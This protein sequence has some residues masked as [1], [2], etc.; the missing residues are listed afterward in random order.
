[1]MRGVGD[2]ICFNPVNLT[3]SLPSQNQRYT[4]LHKYTHKHT[5]IYL[6]VFV[7]CEVYLVSVRQAIFFFV[8]D[9]SFSF[10]SKRK[11]ERGK[12]WMEEK[13]EVRQ[14]RVYKVRAAAGQTSHDATHICQSPPTIHP[15]PPPLSP[16]F[17]RST[18][19][20]IFLYWYLVCVCVCDYS[21]HWSQSGEICEQSCLSRIFSL[22]RFFA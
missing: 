1:M 21:G 10:S 3:I 6:F 12:G 13:G 22:L 9:P 17:P 2:A 14:G 5:I 20:S 8:S 19:A 11:R 4:P 16:L 7:F 15:P 18:S